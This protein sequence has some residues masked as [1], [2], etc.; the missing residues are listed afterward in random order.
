MA[1]VPP[2]GGPGFGGGINI[3]VGGG[4]IGLSG[5]V[6]FGA[7]GIGGGVGVN[8][9]PG[10][11]GLSGGIGIGGAGIG[12]SGGLGFGGLSLSA[13]VGV[14][15]F[16][17]ALIMPRRRNI[18]GIFAQVTIEEQHT[19][20]VQITDHPIEQGAPISDHAFK[21]PIS[22]NINAGWST[23]WAYDLSAES[24][25]YGMLLALQLSFIPFDLVTGKRTYPN[26]LIERLI[27]TTD[28]QS[29]FSLM[30]QIGCRQVIIVKTATT[31][32]SSS[33]SDDPNAHKEG[34]TTPNNPKGDQPTK[35]PDQG[36]ATASAEAARSNDSFSGNLATKGIDLGSTGQ[37]RSQQGAI[38]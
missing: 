21:R 34:G 8:I 4:G 33:A 27:V 25:I 30:T 13:R 35:Q 38:F 32:V 26:M 2:G 22:V 31:S 9:G 19:D 37:A 17:P 20:E 3:G 11:I 10:G 29:E 28:H 24:G 36:S 5:G 18:G 1:A 15:G 6:N 12:I 23:A 14:G 16:M 7:G